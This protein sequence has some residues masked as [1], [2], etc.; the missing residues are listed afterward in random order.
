MRL[1]QKK[2][3]IGVSICV[4]AVTR[5]FGV[6]RPGVLI[7]GII[8]AIIGSRDEDGVLPLLGYVVA[9]IGLVPVLGWINGSSSLIDPLV[10]V[11]ASSLGFAASRVNS[12]VRP[13]I[14]LL[15]A[16]AVFGFS[17]HWWSYFGAS[18]D[19]NKILSRLLGGWDH[20]GHFY[21]YLM[22]LRHDGFAA[23]VS[24]PKAGTVWYDQKYPS[25]IQ[26]A[27]TQWFHASHS[28]VVSHPVL[29]LH[30]Y[31]Q[32]NILTLSIVAGI[33]TLSIA[34]MG[35][36]RTTRLFAGIVGV[37]V[38]IGLV[39]LGPLAMTLWSGFPNFAIAISGAVIVFSLIV[40]P[41]DSG[42]ANALIAIGAGLICTY[43]WYPSVIAVGPAI[44][45]FAW[46]WFRSRKNG[47][48]IAAISSSIGLLLIAA[49]VLLTLSIGVGHIQV[50]GGIQP[51][52][53]GWITT[54]MGFGC[55]IGIWMFLNRRSLHSASIA[56]AFLLPGAFQLAVTVL[57][58]R[59]TGK[60]PY[61]V[62]KIGYITV[63]LA[64]LGGVLLLVERTFGPRAQA[65]LS[66]SRIAGLAA[67]SVVMCLTFTQ[68]F[69]Y[70]GPDW[71][72]VAPMG[73]LTGQTAKQ[74]LDQSAQA[75]ERTA[76]LLVSMSEATSG[77][78]FRQLDCI[79]FFDSDMQ[80]YD[81]VL[82]NY[83]AGVLTWTL[84]EE[85]ISRSQQYGVF[86]TGTA[87]PYANALNLNK[88]VS[89]SRT[90][91][92]VTR[93]VAAHLVDINK[94]WLGR[95]WLIESDGHVSRGPT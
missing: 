75:R 57:V 40:R 51:L 64:F 26:M 52:P 39:T 22:N 87:D 16:F 91:L 77:L 78:P 81:P 44:L 79:T 90:C 23:W 24:T 43:N 36:T 11:S 65:K 60:Y 20:F 66:T 53:A 50:D 41:F 74:G 61:Y 49:P 33:L 83:W 8:V 92:V 72:N 58:R 2:T 47:R 82:A 38:S 89:P 68:V 56:C 62:Q 84:T 15:P 55:A 10:V 45:F 69:G 7:A 18:T 46:D 93:D 34:R 3:F 14:E 42:S 59:S 19:P 73:T 63:A 21:L 67:L 85:H 27:W 76:T 30:N 37:G 88:L 5:I 17:M 4:Y 86:L 1:A 95:L 94:S 28:A 70:T 25:G 12:R 9:A 54:A 13:N 29:L 48:T 35:A 80:A 32:A 31:V 71:V 6:I